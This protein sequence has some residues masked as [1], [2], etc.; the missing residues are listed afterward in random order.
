MGST[1]HLKKYFAI[2]EKVK[3]M[4]TK[5]MREVEKL[6]LS[7]GYN[8]WGSLTL[9]QA[10]EANKIIYNVGKFFSF[11]VIPELRTT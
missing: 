1:W 6:P 8:R 11:L 7:K 2:L 3:K 9:K 4:A 10:E 5:I